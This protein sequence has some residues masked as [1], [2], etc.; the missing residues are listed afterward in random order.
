[1]QTIV[2]ERLTNYFE[3]NPAI[4]KKIIEKSMLA[5]KARE[6]ARKARDLTRRKTVLEGGGTSREISRLL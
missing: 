6:A 3:E 5:A 1:M 2:S 4:I